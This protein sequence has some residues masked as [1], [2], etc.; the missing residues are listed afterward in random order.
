MRTGDRVG[1][2]VRRVAEFFEDQWFDR[3]RRVRTSWDVSLH[4]AGIIEEGDSEAYQ[5]ARP[6]HI[7]QALREM[8]VQDVRGYSFIDLGSGKGRTLFIAAEMPFQRVVGVEFSPVLQAEA[9]RNVRQFRAPAGGCG[10]VVSLHGD[11]ALF[12]FPK[13]PLVLYLFNPFGA[14]TMQRVMERLAE[15]LAQEPRHVVVLLLWP[16]CTGQVLAVP[17]MRMVLERKEYQILEV[18]GPGRKE[19][20]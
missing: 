12:I 3:T 7:R 15:S 1:D 5:P 17:G 8:T 2:T 4:D 10:E 19:E 13:T 6:R 11:A 16:Q 9:E 18:S 14:A 20:G